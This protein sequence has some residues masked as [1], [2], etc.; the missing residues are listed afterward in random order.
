MV[1]R[2]LDGIRLTRHGR[3]KGAASACLF[4]GRRYLDIND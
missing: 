1:T 4:G 3:G 2:N